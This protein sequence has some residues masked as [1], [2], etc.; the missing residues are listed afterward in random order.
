M[1][2][3]TNN[4]TGKITLQTETETLFIISPFIGKRMSYYP[5]GTKLT[6]SYKSIIQADI[7]IVKAKK[8]VTKIPGTN[9]CHAGSNKL[10]NSE[11]RATNA[12]SI[13]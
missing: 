4:I 9:P 6:P 13:S 5:G 11:K 12:A 8:F 2:T 10:F 1:K 7:V 3:K